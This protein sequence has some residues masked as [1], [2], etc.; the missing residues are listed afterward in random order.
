M[1]D[2]AAPDPYAGVLPDADPAGDN[3]HA[4]T[5]FQGSSL[6]RDILPAAPTQTAPPAPPSIL[7]RAWASLKDIGSEI[8]NPTPA[9]ASGP[10]GTAGQFGAGFLQGVQ[11][12]AI[13]PST[14]LL[15]QAGVGDDAT[16]AAAD[17]R[18]QFEKDFGDSTP[19]SIGRVTGQ[20]V[21]TAPVIGGAG[22]AARVAADVVPAI[23]P[24]VTFLGGGTRLAS[25]ASLP[26]RAATAGSS[27]AAQGALTGG[28]QGALTAAPDQST[29][30][31]ALQGATTG[32]IAGPVI[33]AATYPLRAL[34][35]RV[36]NMT[37]PELAQWAQTAKNT[38]GVDVDPS[39]L[40]NN[41]TYKLIADQTG[42]VP[43]S[44]VDET[45]QRQQWQA[46]VARQFGETTDNGIT[47]DVMDRAARRIGG[48]FDGVA[49]RTTVQGGPPLFNDMANIALDMPR[50][51]LTNA[52]PETAKIQAGAQNVLSAFSQGNGRIT[53]H[54]YQTLTQTG[55]PLDTL[56]NSTDP[57]TAAFGMR[58]RNA[59]D[60]AFQRSATP[61]D[62]AALT[63]ARQ[64]YRALKT[65][66][67]L[68][69]QRGATGDIN[70]NALKQRVIAQS[71]RFDPSTGGFA[72]TGGG[73]MGDLANIGSIFFSPSAD[74]GTAA[75]NIVLGGLLGGGVGSVMSHP[76]VLAGTAA[77]L[78]A[79][80]AFQAG[81]RSPAIGRAMIAGT[82]DPASR[83]AQFS[84]QT[85]VPAATGLLNQYRPP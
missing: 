25:T 8:A 58:I 2:D 36:A 40:T 84:N 73:A 67:P 19:A 41:P 37:T 31:A 9:T 79:N 29:T 1:A 23:A 45:A 68:V 69:E 62:Q 35:G 5:P 82:V 38:Y 33:G 81:I 50:Y 7:D 3:T 60:D 64:Q 32:G 20:T 26:A 27:L 85:L 44:G 61:Q 49:N 65:V 12:V 66:Q 55:G 39:R 21:A 46:A 74:S 13:P 77:T 51:G 53:G 76:G 10:P 47:Y 54:A 22:M 18:Q 56:V 78:L 30:D 71:T 48:V 70:P 43:F 59:L 42:K 63:Q 16:K 57:T 14:W 28:T 52:S 6:Y 17:R 83:G 72:Y 75:R 15:R 80:R 34:V 24:A 11:D 4:P